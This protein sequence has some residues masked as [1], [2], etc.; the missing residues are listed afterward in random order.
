MPNTTSYYYWVD[1]Y[2]PIPAAPYWKYVSFLAHREYPNE[3]L[4]HDGWTGPGTPDTGQYQRI[5]GPVIRTPG[6]T[7]ATFDALIQPYK[8]SIQPTPFDDSSD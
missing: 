4:L 5:R 6:M 8:D 2:S 3:S 7:D 1:V